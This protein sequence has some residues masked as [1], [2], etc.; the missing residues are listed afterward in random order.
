M[1]PVY[2]TLYK[3]TLG[4]CCEWKFFQTH[5][6]LTGTTISGSGGTVC[7]SLATG[8]YSGGFESIVILLLVQCREA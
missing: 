1:K 5:K 3:W 6:I 8:W 2:P 7:S 4:L